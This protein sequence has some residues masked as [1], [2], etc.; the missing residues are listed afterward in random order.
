MSGEYISSI[1]NKYGDRD[2]VPA[3]CRT[4]NDII[5]R[6]GTSLLIDCIAEHVGTVALK[7]NMS[8]Q[9]RMNVLHSLVAELREALAERT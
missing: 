6:Q 2:Q 5:S 9:D 1:I 8:P 7:F 4:L 3:D